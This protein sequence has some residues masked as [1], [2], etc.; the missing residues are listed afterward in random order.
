MEEAGPE[1]QRK[2]LIGEGCEREKT[3]EVLEDGLCLSARTRGTIGKDMRG[4]QGSSRHM[5]DASRKR[6]WSCYC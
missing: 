5:V 4:I 6:R 1:T 3:V 2:R